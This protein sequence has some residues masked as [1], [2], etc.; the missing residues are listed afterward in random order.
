MLGTALIGCGGDEPDATPGQP[1]AEEAITAE[2]PP[3]TPPSQATPPEQPAVAP[4]AA[5]QGVVQRAR[6]D[7]PWTPVYTGTVSPGMTRDEVIGVWGE[8][9]A[10]R[11]TGNQTFLFFRNGCEVSCGMLDVVFLEGGQV[12]DAV[13]R[14]Q[15][16]IYGGTSSS[17]PN[18]EA[19]ATLP[20]EMGPS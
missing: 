17:P 6:V 20:G 16:H 1:T 18:A 8:P 13:V 11:A 7:E 15:G 2:A 14:G 12:V 9:I 19:R 5:Q 3:E 10:E 4:P